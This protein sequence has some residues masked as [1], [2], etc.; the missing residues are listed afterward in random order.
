MNLPP[1]EVDGDGGK[2]PDHNVEDIRDSQVSHEHHG[3]AIQTKHRV[4]Q[5]SEDNDQV[6]SYSEY[7]GEQGVHSK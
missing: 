2:H 4:L 5:S 3:D 7:Q 1:S 6:S